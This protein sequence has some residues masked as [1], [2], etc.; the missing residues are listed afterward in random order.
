MLAEVERIEEASA[1]T[2][3]QPLKQRRLGSKDIFKESRM[4]VISHAG[5]EYRLCIT[6]KDK[7]ILVK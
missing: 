7:L 3:C 5:E 4:V 2:A 1:A 6:R